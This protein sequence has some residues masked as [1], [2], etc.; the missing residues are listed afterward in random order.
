MIVVGPYVAWV[1]AP[2][3]TGA[4]SRGPCPYS[5]HRAMTTTTR[6]G[7][8]GAGIVVTV[9]VVGPDADLRV[10]RVVRVGGVVASV[11]P[12]RRTKTA[13]AWARLGTGNAHS[14][15]ALAPMSTTTKMI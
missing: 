11:G 4:S 14:P 12:R 5:S 9:A 10:T 3:S 15:K 8:D 2:G 1:R 6:V 7:E 13:A